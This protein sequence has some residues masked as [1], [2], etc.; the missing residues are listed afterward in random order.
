MVIADL[1]EYYYVTILREKKKNSL[2]CITSKHLMVT[3][4]ITYAPSV[5]NY[6]S[7]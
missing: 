4:H 3:Y 2:F 1:C 5:L 7:Y 6:I